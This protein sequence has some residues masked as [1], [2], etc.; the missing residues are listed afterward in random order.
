[1]N[2]SFFFIVLAAILFAIDWYVWQAVR[3]VIRTSSLTTQRWATGAYWGLSLLTLGAYIIVQLLPP[4]YF[5]KTVRNFVFA[6]IALPYFSK[7][8]AVLFLLVDD[9]RRLVQWGISQ[10][11]PSVA[12]APADPA[13]PRIPRSEFL[14]TTA[15]IA[16]FG[17]SRWS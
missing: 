8:F 6:G 2:R 16:G 14:S 13:L 3:T 4:D 9:F 11:V 1:M 5:N 7:L 12:P 15:L 10:F 17:V